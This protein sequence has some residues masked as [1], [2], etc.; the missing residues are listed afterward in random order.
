[1]EPWFEKS[2]HKFTCFRV[3]ESAAIYADRSANKH[4]ASICNNSETIKIVLYQ[5]RNTEIIADDWLAYI[6]QENFT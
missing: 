5:N 3:L 4:A 2:Y 6:P 1:M